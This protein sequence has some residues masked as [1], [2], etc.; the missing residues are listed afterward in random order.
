MAG[1]ILGVFTLKLIHFKFLWTSSTKISTNYKKW[2]LF[3]QKLFFQQLIPSWIHDL[4]TRTWPNKL[5]G[6][7]RRQ[8]A[9]ESYII[10][11]VNNTLANFC[12]IP[13]FL[14]NRHFHRSP[15]QYHLSF[16]N[17]RRIHNLAIIATLIGSLCHLVLIFCWHWQMF[18]IL[19]V[20]ANFAVSVK[21]ATLKGDPW[22]YLTLGT[23]CPLIVTF[24]NLGKSLPFVLFSPILKD[25][26]AIS[27]DF[28]IRL[29]RMFAK[30]VIFAKYSIFAKI[31]TVKKNPLL[32]YKNIRQTF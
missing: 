4:V 31:A 15:L 17:I 21:I 18:A 30:F 6:V 29:W 12:R 13:H 22:S 20:F 9:L 5:S 16:G 32:P 19:T 2:L 7:P 3:S 11:L 24:A 1:I 8:S 27:F 26:F 14:R 10:W 23:I 28:L 25:P